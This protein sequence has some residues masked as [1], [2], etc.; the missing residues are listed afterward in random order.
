MTTLFYIVPTAIPVILFSAYCNNEGLK[1]Y[2]MYL[3]PNV[4][5]KGLN[6]ILLSAYRKHEGS[7]L[8]FYLVPTVT[9]KGLNLPTIIFFPFT[10]V[11]YLNSVRAY[12]DCCCGLLAQRLRNA[13]SLQQETAYVI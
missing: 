1:F 5:I 13:A 11:S 3:V 6:L 12:V 8:I 2:S 4:T 7:E 10:F 9:M